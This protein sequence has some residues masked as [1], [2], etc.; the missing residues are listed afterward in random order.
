MENEFMIFDSVQN[1]VKATHCSREQVLKTLEYLVNR[2]TRNGM[3]EGKKLE[4][5][6]TEP[7]FQIMKRA[8]PV[9]L[10]L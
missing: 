6:F 7:R 1:E 9:E 2:Y 3:N 8:T 5:G 10:F 4:N